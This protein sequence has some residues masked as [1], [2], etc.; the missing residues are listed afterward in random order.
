M[1]E[2]K[3]FCSAGE[4]ALFSLS[5]TRSTKGFRAFIGA[6]RGV[7]QISAPNVAY[8]SMEDVAQ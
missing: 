2:Q 3:L 5:L 6:V 8:H 4:I 7:L 1:K